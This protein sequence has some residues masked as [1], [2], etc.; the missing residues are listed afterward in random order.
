[1]ILNI[2]FENTMLPLQDQV[3][4]RR[5]GSDHSALTSILSRML[6]SSV[7]WGWEAGLLLSASGKSTAGQAD[8]H[9]PASQQNFSLFY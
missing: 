7:G 5:R 2:N 1:M 9:G 3:E 4:A 8:P 6:G